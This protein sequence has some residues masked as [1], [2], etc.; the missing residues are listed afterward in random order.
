[1][2]LTN[3]ERASD[4][5]V[6]KWLENS[7]EL[8]PYQKEKLRRDETIRFS[9]FYFYKFKK[10]EKSNFFWRLSIILVPFY[11]LALLIA[12]PINLIITGTWGF[13]QNF[14]DNVHSKW[15]RKLGLS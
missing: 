15:M 5:D 12:L 14:Y 3:L 6:Q 10:K 9:S 1:M 11:Y 8:T 2:R 4:Y 7:I 13:G